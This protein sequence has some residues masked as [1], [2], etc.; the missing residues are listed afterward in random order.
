MNIHVRILMLYKEWNGMRRRR[1]ATCF[2]NDLSV[3]FCTVLF[4]CILV[5]YRMVDL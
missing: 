5:P 3:S 2:A 4:Y 1:Y